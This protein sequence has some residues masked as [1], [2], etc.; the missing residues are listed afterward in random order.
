MQ[1]LRLPLLVTL[2][3]AG[4]ATYDTAYDYGSRP[5]GAAVPGRGGAGAAGLLEAQVMGVREG[6][7]TGPASIDVRLRV[8]RFGATTVAVPVESLQLL[9]G[10]REPLGV[11][12]VRAIGP[13]VAASGGA[14]AYQ[15]TFSLPGRDPAIF[16]LSGLDL[17][18]PVDVD[19]QRSTVRIAFQRGATAYI[20]ADPREWP[21]PDYNGR[22]T[23][24]RK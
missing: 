20:W 1:R 22:P 16:D 11:K 21:G 10:D 19:G 24:W 3:L 5:N 23:G 2:L 13:A 6:D 14:A 17:M 4:C 8:Q 9:T 7:A 15:A 12:D 18:V